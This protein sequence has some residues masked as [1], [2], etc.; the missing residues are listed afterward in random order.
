M[1]NKANLIV[2]SS[3]FVVRSKDIENQVEK[4]KPISNGHFIIKIMRQ[5]S[6]I[7]SS[8]QSGRIERFLLESHRF[9][10]K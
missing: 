7:L 2:H 3:W 1:E 8:I 5:K 4:T 9:V 6:L 10:V